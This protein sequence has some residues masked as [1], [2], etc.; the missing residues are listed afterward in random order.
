M[1]IDKIM[2]WLESVDNV[3]QNLIDSVRDIHTNIFIESSEDVVTQTKNKITEMNPD[4]TASISNELDSD[5]FNDES[6]NNGDLGNNEGSENNE[7]TDP[8]LDTEFD[9]LDKMIADNL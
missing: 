1:S 9:E 2:S 3:D 6:G 8:T 7:F 5:V 4:H